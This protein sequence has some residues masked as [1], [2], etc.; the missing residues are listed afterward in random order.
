MS[1]KYFAMHQIPGFRKDLENEKSK[2]IRISSEK[3]SKIGRKRNVG[4]SSKVGIFPVKSEDVVTLA[5]TLIT[6]F[7]VLQIFF[8]KFLSSVDFNSICTSCT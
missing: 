2:K 1:L 3:D 5:S 7:V 4:K 6:I 8:T